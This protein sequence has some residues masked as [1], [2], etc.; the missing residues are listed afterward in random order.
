MRIVDVETVVAHS[1]S[2]SNVSPWECLS[3]GTRAQVKPFCETCGAAMPVEGAEDSA[4]SMM[5]GLVCTTCDTFNDP[6]VAVCASCGTALV[7]SS[8][9]LPV[10]MTPVGGL[11]DGIEFDPK[12]QPPVVVG[13]LAAEAPEG[14]RASGVPAEPA[15]REAPR[16]ASLPAMPA[17]M[18]PP[19]GQPL[20][21]QFALPKVDLA[22]VARDGQGLAAPKPSE[23]H[24]PFNPTAT[25]IATPMP[26]PAPVAAQ[27]Q[28]K[29]AQAPHAPPGCWRC[30]VP[31]EQDDKFCRNCG[32]RTDA[33]AA[34][35]LATT[36][37]AAAKMP[38]PLP[39]AVMPAGATM[40]MPAMRAA[41]AQPQG[42]PGGADARAAASGGAVGAGATLM[43]SAQT[44]E[45]SAKLILVRG[46]SQ[47]GSQWRL[48]ASETIIGR[49]PTMSAAAIPFPDDVAMA[50]NHC[51][52]VFRGAGQGEL[53]LEPE[54]SL[55]GVFLRL[56][57]P[58]RLVPGD[59][60]VV[61]AQRLR[62]L[63]DDER[64]HVV[65]PEVGGS[66][67]VLGSLVRQSPPIMLL[68][69]AADPLLNEVFHRCQRLLTIGRNN[70][71]L[72]FPRDSFVSERHAQVTH[73]GTAL[74]VEDL[75]S[76]NGTYVRA[77]APTKLSHGDL[78]LLGDKVVR[79]E[80]PR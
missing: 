20:A 73:E 26:P 70:C 17:W 25:P 11:G 33:P 44:G 69:V 24:A 79:V 66:T 78:V 2:V 71:D 22:S 59:E 12:T 68:R 48:T 54:E 76:R 19:P 53:W 75:R 28:A 34:S 72:N 3:C 13:S 38:G 52:L 63:A 23:P 40:V 47:Y 27:A 46:Q 42:I 64:P 36:Q 65:R 62:I 37:I 30:G 14:P 35:P 39:T 18:S 58:T 61:G 7:E 56:R 32:A 77:R 16:A 49:A 50:A 74:V 21:T 15:P 31:L 8:G 6:G 51:R 5:L 80:I 29:Q 57:E 43:F 60:I 1:R 4:L 55:N 41:Q 9:E 67:R 45:R 10:A